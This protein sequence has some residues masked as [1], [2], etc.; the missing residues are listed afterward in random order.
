M[1]SPFNVMGRQCVWQGRHKG[2]PLKSLISAEIPY[3]PLE[4]SV[5]G[6]YCLLLGELSGPSQRWHCGLFPKSQFLHFSFQLKYLKALVV[7]WHHL[8]AECKKLRTAKYLGASLTVWLE[9]AKSCSGF[10]IL[11][12]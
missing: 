7:T 5:L 12:L 4:G 10:S 6:S 11:C 8:C 1:G 2:S 3:M 9:I